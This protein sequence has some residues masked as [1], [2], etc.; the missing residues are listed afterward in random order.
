MATKQNIRNRQIVFADPYIGYFMENVYYAKAYGF[1]HLC[2]KISWIFYIHFPLMFW[3][4]LMSNLFSLSEPLFLF[5]E[6]E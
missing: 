5:C 6:M 2:T 4:T 3:T 1:Q